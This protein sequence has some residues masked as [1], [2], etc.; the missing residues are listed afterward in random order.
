[1]LKVKLLDERATLPTVANPGEDLGYDLYALEDT[2]VPFGTVTKI[3]TG[4]AVEGVVVG[5]DKRLGF[6]V[7]DRSSMASLGFIVTGGVIDTGYRGEII[8]MMNRLSPSEPAK[9]KHTIKAGE[10]FAQLVPMPVLTGLVVQTDTLT[11]TMRGDKGF[12]SSGK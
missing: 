4:I 3:R 5:F 7:R 9:M 8:V 12:G 11:E 1:M 10:K 2:H 6:L